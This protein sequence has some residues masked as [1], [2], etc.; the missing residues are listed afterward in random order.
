MALF[1]RRLL[2]ALGLILTAA[3][4]SCGGGRPPPPPAPSSV[5][6]LPTDGPACVANL[7][8]ANVAFDR[9]ADFRN[10][11]GC[12]I[13]TAVSLYEGAATPLNRPVKVSCGLAAAV[14][15]WERDVLHPLAQR[16]V[17]QPLVKVHHVGGY[18]CRGRTSDRSRLS[19][20]AHGRAID[21]IAFEF[22]DGRIARVVE[23]WND[24]GPL[25]RFLREASMGAC[26]AFQVVLSPNADASHRD[27]LHLDVGPWKLCQG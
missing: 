1:S 11:R 4:A 14:L 21:V 18:V 12:G 5:S 25:G 24:R 8:S 3:L 2:T 13:S 22:A 9:V 27:H 10:E 16:V 19:E 15:A 6:G 7:V 23:H 26:G 20:H 17:G